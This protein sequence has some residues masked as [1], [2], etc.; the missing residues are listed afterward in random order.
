MHVLCPAL[1]CLPAL[2][3]A[4]QAPLTL[5]SPEPRLLDLRNADL[6]AVLPADTR[7]PVQVEGARMSLEALAG[8]FRGE[9][10]VRLLLPRGEDRGR[11]LLGV[12]QALKAQNPAQKVYLAFDPHMEALWDETLWGAL[13]G[14]ALLPGDLGQDAAQW[15]RR[16]T[17]AQELLPGRPWTLWT[18]RDPGPL[19]AT[20]LGDGGRL[21]VPRGGPC[22]HLAEQVP[23]G[24]T[25]AV[26]GT[27]D[28]TFR[29]P[30]TGAQRRWRFQGGAWMPVELARGAHEVA[31]TARDLYDVGALLARVRATGLRDRSALRHLEASLAVDLHIQ[32][33]GGAGTDLGYRFRYFQKAGEAEELLQ[34][35]VLFNGVRA[36]LKGQ[37]QLPVIEA[38][39][40]SALPVAL[41]LSERYRYQDAGAG[42][43]PG[44]RLV[45]FRPADGDATLY[46]GQLL[47]DE[48]TG[49]ILE[50]R[51]HREGLPGTVKSE[52][53]TLT[54]GEPA[55]G[56]WTLTSLE[57][58]DRWFIATDALL[59]KRRWTLSEFRV[60]EGAFET[61]RREARGSREAMLVQTPEGLR[62]YAR[63]QD[64]TRRVDDRS[65]TAGRALGAFLLVDPS[66]EVP[67]A[68]MAALAMYDFDAWGKGIQYQFLSAVVFNAGSI[69]YPGAFLGFDLQAGAAL[70]LM[71]G[72]DRPVRGGKLLDQEGVGHRTQ[73]ASTSIGRDLGLGLRFT[74]GGDFAWNHYS[75]APETKYRSQDFRLPPSGVD[76]RGTASLQWQGRGFVLK[77]SLGAGR[78]PEGIYGLPGEPAAVPDGGRYHQWSGM[79]G[80]NLDLGQGRW[81]DLGAGH[82]AGTGFDRF[83]SIESSGMGGDG[84]PPGLKGN[85]IASDRVDYARLGCILPTGPS[86]RL[87]LKVEYARMRSLDDGKTYGFTGLGVAGD[88]PGLW[89]FTTT[90]VDL[91]FGLQSS[92]RGLRTVNGMVSLLRV[93]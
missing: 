7:D 52:S 86:L 33:L 93:F 12:C 78:R 9:A 27:G 84:M 72:T 67:V 45:A 44:T 41:A 59:V 8:P 79:A 76:R 35:E 60:N 74:L 26:G 2:C 32:D 80:Y 87:G 49:R 88:L 71:T 47:V 64:G 30:A 18:P 31:V 6:R 24:F 70:T 38:R 3:A 43:R 13:D 61:S 17:R 51:S 65:R 77:G 66:S 58:Y 50:E 69:A 25:E 63:Q 21:V 82:L 19:C 4:A 62:Y 90:R 73:T 20:L 29:H 53:R 5:D 22:A 39:T 14:G 48:G 81:L 28:L 46:A 54:Y 85:A 68:P 23:P 57:S 92:I 36:N 10:S 37:A 91:G 34:K 75:L 40:T 83:K 56:L 89:W 16:L 1:L 15:E 55:P 42:P 11:L